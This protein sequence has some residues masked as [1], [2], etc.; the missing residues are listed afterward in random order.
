[1]DKILDSIAVI[2]LIKYVLFY[3]S[4]KNIRLKKSDRLTDGHGKTKSEELAKSTRT[5]FRHIFTHITLLKLFKFP[6]KLIKYLEGGIINAPQDSVIA[7]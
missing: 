7:P 2:L 3:R 1:M 5:I 4:E 6:F